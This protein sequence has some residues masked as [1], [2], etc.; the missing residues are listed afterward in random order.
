M[1]T[2]GLPYGLQNMLKEGSTHLSGLEEAVL[3]NVEACK[4]LSQ[5]T[6]TSLGPHGTTPLRCEG[7]FNSPLPPPSATF[8]GVQ[9]K[10]EGVGANPQG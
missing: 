5:M 10:G 2:H 1:G 7:I 8:R 3:K 9:I 4:Q 6:R